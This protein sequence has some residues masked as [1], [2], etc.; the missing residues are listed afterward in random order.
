MG[1]PLSFHQIGITSSNKTNNPTRQKK[2]STP[3]RYSTLNY[4]AEIYLFHFGSSTT[5]VQQPFTK[6]VYYYYYQGQIFLKKVKLCCWAQKPV[7]IN[8]TKIWHCILELQLF[9]SSQ[10]K[11][12]LTGLFFKNPSDSAGHH[13]KTNSTLTIKIF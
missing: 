9:L 3:L 2:F 7:Q 13:Q 5:I 4:C 11:S 10:M 1:D 12:K 6:H 8:V